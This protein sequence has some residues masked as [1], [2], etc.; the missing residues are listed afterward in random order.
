MSS[1]TETTPLATRKK[2]IVKKEAYGESMEI[3][4]SNP[5]TR[6]LPPA[7]ERSPW[8]RFL[9]RVLLGLKPYKSHAP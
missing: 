6:F 7:D 8:R 2:F 3:L 1:A 5:E 4:D 9:D